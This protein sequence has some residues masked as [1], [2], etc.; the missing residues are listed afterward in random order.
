MNEKLSTPLLLDGATG[1]NLMA[2]GM[3]SGVCVEKWVL[4]NPNAIKELQSRFVEAGSD[5]VYAP[6]FSANAAKLGHFGLAG[7]VAELNARL[8]ALSKEAVGG[9]ALVA[10]DMSPTGL[11]L[12]PFGDAAFDDVLAIYSEQALS[13]I[14]I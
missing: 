5:V 6:T 10:G 9:R 4:E 14:H 11:I 13:L 3:P 2:A 1:T 7:Q 12:E 8:V